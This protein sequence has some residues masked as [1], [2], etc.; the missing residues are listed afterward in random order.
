[1]RVSYRLLLFF[2]LLCISSSPV[3][4]QTTGAFDTTFAFI[5]A[6]RAVS[7]YVPPNYEDTNAYR[8]M[9]C[10]HGLGDTCTNYRNALVES[11]AWPTHFPNTIFVCPEAATTTADFDQTASDG[12]IVDSCIKFAMTNY[13]IDT[14]DV[15]LQ[16][17]SLGGR[18]A[19]RYGLEYY[20]KFKALLLNTPAIQGVKNA[21]NGQPTYLFD[22]THASD[23]P[24]YITHGE[25]DVFYEPPIDSA[26]KQLVRNDGIVRYND[27]PRIG[28]TIPYFSQMPDALQFIDTPA[29]ARN[30]VELFELDAP[31]RIITSSI[32]SQVL[33]RNVGTDTI[34]SV[35][36]GIAQGT[37][38]TLFTWNGSLIPFQHAMITLPAQFVES[39]SGQNILNVRIDSI[40]GTADTLTDNEK[41][42]T[43][44]S[45]SQGM[46]LPL[47][48]G[49]EENT[50]P[51]PGWMLQLA[52]DIF[53]PWFQD[54]VRKSGAFSAGAF[55]SIFY[56]DNS[57]RAEGLLSPVLDLTSAPSP[58]LSFDLAYNFDEYTPPYFTGTF[59][60]TD[61]L[62]VLIST[63]G[64]VTYTSL[65]RSN[66][67]DLATF[68]GPIINPLTVDA[69]FINPADSNWRHYTLDLSQYASAPEAII[70]FNYVSG[71]GGSIYIDN[72]NVGSP[73]AGVQV[74]TPIACSVYPNPA[75]DRVTITGDPNSTAAITILDV[76]GR[77]VLSR[78]GMT[79]GSG[80][81]ALNTHALVP[82][83]YLAR[84]AIGRDA[85]T[86]K[87]AIER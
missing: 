79:D 45:V 61:T 33:V 64:G 34:S 53:S 67:A 11:L 77:E 62:N 55:N 42:D 18:A 35:T 5:G 80:A 7:C 41:I 32:P 57:G 50:F 21:L 85:S 84:I 37:F 20:S 70:K 38:R 14:S 56:F 28:H 30:D 3:T 40:N 60:L 29:R 83:I 54:T 4:A 17:F 31:A 68:A 52:G 66:G 72:V 2:F 44:E 9:V 87:L 23:I 82:G 47:S 78:G 76:A 16:G 65:F 39:G 13:H 24:I 46:P 8:L 43:F 49:F 73:L 63:D 48:E 12:S 22:Y 51:P 86:V 15:I 36:L 26:L 25:T 74:S 59:D 10:L 71:L 81:F 75:A 19:L 69:V 1:M 58:Q 27:V 6:S